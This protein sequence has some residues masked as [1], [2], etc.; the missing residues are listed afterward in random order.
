MLGEYGYFDRNASGER[1][2]CL[3][4][5]DEL[6]EEHTDSITVLHRR[7]MRDSATPWRKVDE[8]PGGTLR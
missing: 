4:R 2:V 1:F 7:E 6:L 8:W 5:L 3:G